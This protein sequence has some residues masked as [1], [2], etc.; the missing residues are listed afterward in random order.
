MMR[1][2]TDRLAASSATTTGNGRHIRPRRISTPFE[3]YLE[4]DDR[5]PNLGV[6]DV[7]LD[8]M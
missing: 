3:R 8:S 4:R 2:H 7:M 5:P 6:R 1:R